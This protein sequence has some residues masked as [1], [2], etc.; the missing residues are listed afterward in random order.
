M[1]MQRVGKTDRMGIC[2]IF[3]SAEDEST[4]CGR[5]L[6]KDASRAALSNFLDY[7]RRRDCATHLVYFENF[8]NYYCLIN[9]YDMVQTYIVL[10]MLGG[11]VTGAVVQVTDILACEK[12]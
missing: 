9:D 3:R 7:H 4:T 5:I 8:I 6:C 2:I 12:L 10:V 1:V 11:N